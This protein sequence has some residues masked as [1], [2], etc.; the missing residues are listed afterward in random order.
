MFKKKFWQKITGAS[1]IDDDYEEYEEYDEYDE[2]EDGQVQDNL[3]E[4][5]QDN[6][7]TGEL[8]VDIY[9]DDNN[10]YIEAF[11][12]GVP[13]ENIDIE[14]SREM[15]NIYGSRTNTKLDSNDFEYFYQ[16]LNW[17]DF[18]RSIV[19]PE[20][21]DIDESEAVEQN[22]VLK[23]TLPKFN[24]SRKAKLKVKSVKK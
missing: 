14:L 9:Q 4:D 11:I 5:V 7:A 18:E 20:E 3:D 15:I 22:G 13:I 12:P 24:K 19:L 1:I 6:K 21:I 17:G 10:I 2:Y 16:E 8:P 23:I